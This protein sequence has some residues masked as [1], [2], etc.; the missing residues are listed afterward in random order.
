MCDARYKGVAQPGGVVLGGQSAE[1]F[2]HF[3]CARGVSDPKGRQVNWLSSNTS[4]RA[5]SKPVARK[6][7]K[8]TSYNALS[9]PSAEKSRSPITVRYLLTAQKISVP[10]KATRACVPFTNT[11]K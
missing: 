3:R 10:P 7:A 2:G 1:S 9:F 5:P 6:Q 8:P 4:L 11:V